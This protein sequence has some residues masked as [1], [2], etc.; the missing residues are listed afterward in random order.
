MG[1]TASHTGTRALV[2]RFGALWRPRRVRV[3]RSRLAPTLFGARVA[4]FY[5][6][7]LAAYY[8]APY[9]NL[10]FLL[11]GFLGL[12]W[13]FALP[14]SWRSLRGVEVRARAAEHEIAAGAAGRLEAVLER[15]ARGTAFD[16]T[17]ELV[18]RNARGERALATG[19]A[20]SVRGAR[21]V[22]VDV[23]AL[24]RGVWEVEAARLVSTYPFGVLRRA[25]AVAYSATLVVHPTPT[26]VRDAQGGSPRALIEALAEGDAA[27]S[28]GADDALQP[29]GLRD[30]REGESLRRVSWRAS[31]R[32]DRL[33][34]QEWDASAGD[35]LEVVLDRR[36][37]PAA[38]EAAFSDL[39]AIVLVARE[40][41]EVL[42][43]RTQGLDRAFGEGRGRWAS[44]LRFLAEAEPLDADG[45]PPPPASPG[46]LRLPARPVRTRDARTRARGEVQ[47]ARA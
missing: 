9:V 14:W 8:A 46:V 15:R 28:A 26:A 17:L 35:G 22:V 4:F 23:P 37:D 21:S 12:F 38:L 34:V 47:R 20:A 24:A 3:R 19:R 7:V 1:T 44:A 30:H 39:A 29:A 10:F 2:R 11:L 25:R 13:A 18:L 16:V 6:V 32:R 31:A 45:P 40:C 41:K 42:A 27:P 33:V 36:A 43:I 5:V